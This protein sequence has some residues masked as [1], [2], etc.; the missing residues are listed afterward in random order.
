MWSKNK[1]KYVRSLAM[2]KVRDAESLFVAGSGNSAIPYLRKYVAAVEQAKGTP[3]VSALYALG[4]SLY[5]QSDY[6]GATSALR[7]VTADDSA[8]GQNAYLYLGLALLHLDDTD[9]AIMAF[10]RAL[11]LDHDPQARENAYYNYAVASTRGGTVPFGSSVR[12]FESFLADFPDSP[13]A[14][15]V[16]DYV[17]TGYV[18]DN[19]YEAA[20]D[21]VGLGDKVGGDALTLQKRLCAGK[22]LLIVLLAV[23]HL[24]QVV[25]GHHARLGVEVAGQEG[26]AGGGVVAFGVE[27]VTQVEVGGVAEFPVTAEGCEDLRG[28]VGLA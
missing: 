11:R 25:V 23:V 16:R 12:T 20:Q 2:K 28:A 3:A 7:P 19:N 21:A 10:D 8:M 17:I 15:E 26:L 6:S 4:V 22:G 24:H 14:A 27:D 5:Q 13:H 9:G 1:S 18:T